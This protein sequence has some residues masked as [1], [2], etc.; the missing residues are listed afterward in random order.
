[1]ITL[2]RVNAAVTI[3]ATVLLGALMVHRFLDSPDGQIF[4]RKAAARWLAFSAECEPC[5][6]RKFLLKEYARKLRQTEYDARRIVETGGDAFDVPS[7]P[8]IVGPS[9]V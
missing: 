5:A 6:Q 9:D 4:K 3:G 1:M 7:V 8:D 2:D